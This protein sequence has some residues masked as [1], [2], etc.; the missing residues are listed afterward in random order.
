M[1]IRICFLLVLLIACNVTYAQLCQGSLGDPVVNITFGHGPNPGPPLSAAT[2]SYSYV[3][4]DCPND[5]SYTVRNSS[6]ACFGNS[7]YTLT[8]DHTGD[9]QGYFMLVNASYQ[10]SEFY[11]DTVR[12]LC[13]NTT[14]QFAAW[15]LNILNFN[16]QC[17]PPIL[18]NLTFTI[19]STD[20]KDTLQRYS[21]GDLT[22]DQIP[23]WKQYG[24]YFKTPSDINDVVVRIRNNAPGG[25]GND[26]A[27]D[28]ITFSPCGPK[29]TAAIGIPNS[30]S[31]KTVCDY[32]T[33][34][35]TLNASVS[36]GY[37]SPAYQWQ[38]STDNVNWTDITG[39]TKLTYSRNP[40]ATGTYYYRIAVA[41]AGNINSPKCRVV[42][43]NIVFTVQGKPV[44]SASSNSPVCEGASLTLTAGGGSGYVWTGP[45]NYNSAVSP[46]TITNVSLNAAGKYFVK[47]T[48]DAGC[49][50][51]DSTVVTVVAKPIVDAGTDANICEGNSITLHATGSNNYTWTPASYLS[52]TNI[53]DPVATPPDS[54]VYTVTT[55]SDATG[56]SA[57][58]SVAVNVFSKPTAD[59]G[60]DKAMIEGESV[61]LSATATGAG[62]IYSWTP[63]AFMNDASVLNP[64]VSPPHDTTYTLTVTSQVGCGVATDHVFVKV[65]KK[66]VVPNAFSPNRDGIND[67]WKIV[68]LDAYP[69][70]I[71]T[72]FNRYGQVVYTGRS[73]SNAWDG[74]YNSKP[75]PVGTYYY[76]IDLKAPVPMLKGWVAILR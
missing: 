27:L 58:D 31:V 6:A 66:V 57:Q 43:N 68:A 26:L 29:V 2:T 47:V 37:T 21:T 33:Q 69:D 50:N 36:D 8:Q 76:V 61:Q 3:A 51:T 46:S 23:T 49:V 62:V 34:S 52:A 30:P 41:E 48:T 12:G 56:C 75:L 39:A 35:Y 44:A 65:Y 18:P 63:N 25:C 38:V 10:P 1:K 13:P 20:G 59:A 28:D 17:N 16:S 53:A 4:N 40:T 64:V 71:V 32:D 45:N 14:F 24:F 9:P 5:G 67:T 7:W 70:A 72:V 11:L 74:T 15:I 54:I 42:S 19:E 55:L 60:P 73:N 22:M